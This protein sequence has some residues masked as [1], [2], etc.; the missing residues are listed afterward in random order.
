MTGRKDCF[1]GEIIYE[2]KISGT[3]KEQVRLY[4][5]SEYSFEAGLP[6]ICNG[7]LVGLTQTVFETRVGLSCVQ[8]LDETELTE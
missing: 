2:R 4:T 8:W 6:T 1:F 5:V 7:W 3:G